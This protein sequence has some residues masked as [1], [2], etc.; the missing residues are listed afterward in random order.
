MRSTK[1]IPLFVTWLALA[2]VTLLTSLTDYSHVFYQHAAETE[3]RLWLE[4]GARNPHSAAHFGQ[5]AYRPE[6]IMAVIE[7]G[8]D[9]W[10][11]TAIWME[12]HYQN[13]AVQRSGDDA[14]PLS[15]LGVLSFG[16]LL[17]VLMP[18]T[19][20]ILG[21]EIL[22]AER[23]S[24][25][26]RLLL[27]CGVSALR[28]LT[29]KGLA[30]IGIVFF[31]TLP[32]WMGVGLVL[33]FARNIAFSDGVF[34]L[35]LWMG[36]YL[37]YGL[38]WV[39]LVLFVSAVAKSSRQSLMLLLAFWV[40]GVLLLPRLAAEYAETQYP[41]PQ[42]AQF[43]TEAYKL[44][45]EGIDGH[46]RRN[47][48]V[49]LL[50]EE[51]FKRYGVNRVED[52]PVS[53][54]GILLQA[55]E[56]Y[57]N[58]IFDLFHGARW[59]SYAE[60]DR[61]SQRW[62]WVSPVIAVRALATQ[63]SGTDLMHHRHFADAAENHRRVLLQFLN[64]DMTNHAKGLDFAYKADP[65]LWKA[66]P[67]WDYMLPRLENLAITPMMILVFWLIFGSLVCFLVARWLERD[68]GA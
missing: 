11:G 60:Q 32:A 48:G 58:L 34:R 65:A 1:L 64:Q 55:G 24:G 51:T 23:V 5:Y 49:N 10:I 53:F 39:M 7:P 33:I 43:W 17:Q 68:V 46:G 14:T 4:Q 44:Q 26:L 57:G 40:I 19:V 28:L 27:S 42:A 16:W 2:I 22:T 25:R 45:Q 59:A 36:F 12:G 56:E 35:S 20:L 13:P 18:L 8:L 61:L 66:A 52:L 37:V 62:A 31:T 3:Q 29:G 38:I 67:R 6:N 30:L 63:V 41:S 9:T 50:E 21:Y 54:A 15:R 47:L